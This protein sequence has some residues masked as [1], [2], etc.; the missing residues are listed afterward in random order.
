MAEEFTYDLTQLLD[1]A[2]VLTSGEPA[3]RVD[4]NAR[5]ESLMIRFRTLM[6]FFYKAAERPT[7]V[8]AWEYLPDSD[9]AQACAR[10]EAERPDAYLTFGVDEKWLMQAVIVRVGHAS[11]DRLYHMSWP[12]Q[13][14]AV[15]VAR[16]WAAFLDRLGPDYRSAFESHMCHDIEVMPGGELRIERSPFARHG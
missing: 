1:V 16:V 13:F 7:D 14:I 11:V 10:W 8:R 12:A 6:E 9:A 2:H 15:G 3:S 5:V 4:H